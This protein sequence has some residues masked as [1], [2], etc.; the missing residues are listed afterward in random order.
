MTAAALLLCG[1]C[2]AD[3]TMDEAGTSGSDDASGTSGGSTDPSGTTDDEESTTDPTDPTDAT[4]PTVD[5]SSGSDESSTTDDASTSSTT[6]DPST[7][8][9]T[10]VD[11]MLGTLECACD[12]DTCQEG[13]CRDDLCVEPV[14]GDG[15]LEGDE[16]CDDGNA[17]PQD[18]CEADCTASQGVAKIAAGDQHAC[19]LFHDGR[20]RCWGHNAYGK[21]GYGNLENIGDDEV[22]AAAGD[23][24]VG[25]A[26]VDVAAGR[27]HTCIL[28]ES[29]GVRCW[30][31]NNRGQLGIPSIPL[32]ETI[33]DESSEVPSMLQD[34]NLGPVP[35]VEIT[36]TSWST[37]VRHEDGTV[38]CFG[39]NG[40]FGTCGYGTT[41]YS[42]GDDEH[43]VVEGPIQLGAAAIDI[44]G[45][46]DHACAVL[47]DGNV[48]C[49]GFNEHGALGLGHLDVVGDDEH[50]SDVPAL[51]FAEP[52]VE[53][54]T[55]LR[56]TCAISES[57]SVK[58]WGLNVNGELGLGHAD[59][60]DDVDAA[61]ALSLGG[62]PLDLAVGGHHGCAWLGGTSVR[63]W[64][65]GGHG[66]L[67]YGSTSNVGDD[68]LPSSMSELELAVLSVHQVEVGNAFS[69]ARV[70][71]GEVICWGANTA[72]QIGL[73]GGQQVGDNET[74]GGLSPIELED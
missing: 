13:V 50:P 61:G 37:L 71:D 43:P 57:G 15:L 47:E 20:L 18:G 45:H 44:D 3:V 21:L 51:S 39:Q 31:F 22:P 1:G 8:G 9:S 58:C 48:R 68:E 26:V 66:R 52:V 35:V 41:E 23:V 11:C 7:S 49:W 34:V 29:G 27:E 32:L 36:A 67:G 40:S 30:G 28:T 19:A 24:D 56:H 60:V 65:S 38:R 64:G 62:T 59:N 12:G 10:G 74:L 33:G 4:D 53:V 16:A 6:E 54:Q 2:F 5:P 55:G 69:C 73:P 63:C 42:F 14:C 72:G 25:E 17:S 46:G 70:D